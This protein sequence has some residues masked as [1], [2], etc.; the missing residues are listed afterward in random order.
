MLPLTN[1]SHPF[2]TTHGVVN[3]ICI[4]LLKY[5]ET[6]TKILEDS[7]NVQGNNF[8]FIHVEQVQK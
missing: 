5:I 3:Q 8:T 4:I 6:H 1:D 7:Y 2:F